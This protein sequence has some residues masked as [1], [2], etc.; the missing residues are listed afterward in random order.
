MAGSEF[1]NG[2][3]NGAERLRIVVVGGVAGGASAAARARRVNSTAEI[4]V[5]EKGPYVS[6]ANCGL[7]Y[8][9]GGEIAERSK[10][11]VATKELFWNRFRIA[12]KTGFEVTQIDRELKQVRGIDHGSGEPFS[13]P[14]DRL[15]LSTGSEPISPPFMTPACDNVSHLW[16][17]GDMD[18][19]L[20]EMAK[21]VGARPIRHAVVVGGGFVGL[22]VVEQ[23]I[24]RGI[25]VALVERNPQ[26]LKP[27]DWQFA[28]II[29]RDMVKQGVQMHLGADIVALRRE[30][31]RATGVV[32][33]DATV[34]ETDLV[35][36]GA[37]VRPRTSLAIQAGLAIGKTGGVVVDAFMR[38]TDPSIYAVGDMVEYMHGVLNEPMRIPLAGPANR[39]GR[40]AGAHAA[41]GRS[42]PMGPV[43]G[44]SIVRVFELTAACTG[45]NETTLAARRIDHHSVI[46]EAGHHAGYFPGAESMRLKLVYSPQ[47]GKIL[48]AQGVGG[49]GVDKRIDV[50]AT[51]MQFG[52]TV[53]QLAQADLAYAP[54]FGSAKDPVHMAAFAAI[55]DLEQCPGVLPPDADLA[56]YQVVDVRGGRELQTLPLAGATAIPVD[57]LVERWRELDP[58]RP[59]V[60]VCHTGK[61]AHV[62]ACWLKGNGFSDVRNLTGGMSMPSICDGT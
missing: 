61:R 39:A 37:G 50:I 18:A 8:H 29:E 17:L 16:T 47:D 46:I 42:E 7:P 38:T 57:E 31:T 62:A 22:E 19:I 20:A 49:Q 11:L 25:K 34:V 10:L 41:A 12:V 45:L 13:V 43:L 30:G 36:V 51:A 26:V 32:L 14:Y 2:K 1:D 44:T 28:R 59:T 9:L 56:G 4:T 27:L 55:N 21:G 23:L 35:V 15:I 3:S 53:H 33:G 48:G 54:P 40:I 58:T 24:R 6:F 52:A 5:L 60:V